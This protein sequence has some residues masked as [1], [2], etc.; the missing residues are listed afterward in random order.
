[1]SIGPSAGSDLGNLADELA[2]AWDDGEEEDP[3]GSSQLDGSFLQDQ[4]TPPQTPLKY[5]PDNIRDSGI[6]VSSPNGS[7]DTPS[8]SP[9]H[10]RHHSKS[11]HAKRKSQSRSVDSAETDGSDFPKNLQLCMKEVDTLA[12]P[13]RANDD[14]IEVHPEQE[15]PTT[16]LVSSLKQ[17]GGQQP[18]IESQ[19]T[20][21]ITAHTS[22][23]S[24]LASTTR[25]LQSL[26]Y[27]FTS[28]LSS[29]PLLD[30]EEIED[31]LCALSDAIDFL[32]RPTKDALSGLD[33]LAAASKETIR[34]LS[35]L[36][37]HLHM[38]RQGTEAAARRLK[39]T[40]EIVAQLREGLK[41]AD[42]GALWIERGQWDQKLANRE[43]ATACRDIVGGF[44]ETC[45]SLRKRL[46]ED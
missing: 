16:R 4:T 5:D 11:K 44:E 2:T 26:T 7:K 39:G 13:A 23:A 3:N 8:A 43:S 46:L 34:S 15:D 25:T 12:N 22:L 27:Y 24:H 45:E 40:K 9:T 38:T 36:S 32:P 33:R 42:D 41:R 10:Q 6:D 19:A 35:G 20:R 31:I 37:D 21:L 1:M 29:Q 28:P 30:D 14:V 18:D 17:L